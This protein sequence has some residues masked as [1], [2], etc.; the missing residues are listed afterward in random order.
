MVAILGFRAESK[1]QEKQ[2]IFIHQKRVFESPF[3]LVFLLYLIVI[4]N[5]RNVYFVQSP[6]AYCD[7]FLVKHI[8]YPCLIVR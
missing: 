2:F 5:V 7:L 6:I 4:N 8:H 1:I 3:M